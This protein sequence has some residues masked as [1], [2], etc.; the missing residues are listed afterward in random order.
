MYIYIE[1]KLC[2]CLCPSS[3]RL[4]QQ[5]SAPGLTE[6]PR[7]LVIIWIV[8]WGPPGRVNLI[9]YKQCITIKRYRE[10]L[11]IYIT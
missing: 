2:C 6:S 9:R 4:D 1:I 10:I 7:S 3:A 5:H 8:I 11:F